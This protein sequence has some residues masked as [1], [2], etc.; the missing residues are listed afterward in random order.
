MNKRGSSVEWFRGE[1]LSTLWITCL[2]ATLSTTNR[3]WN[4]RGMNPELQGETLIKP[5]I[6]KITLNE[7]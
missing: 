6:N 1:N 3:T 7:I 2:T 5:Q 4:N